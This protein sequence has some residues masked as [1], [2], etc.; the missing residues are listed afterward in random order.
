LYSR[1]GL[2]AW[3]GVGC[4]TLGSAVGFYAAGV[5]WALALF[6]GLCVALGL[7]FA[8]L[9]AWMQAPKFNWRFGGFLVG[10]ALSGAVLGMGAG[11]IVAVVTHH[12]NLSSGE[13]WFKVA[14]AVVSGFPISS[15]VVL[16]LVAVMYATAA[17]RRSLMQKALDD[18][19]LTQ[20]RDAAARQAAEAQL[21]LLRA[22]IQ[23][24]F[25]FNTLSALQHWVDTAGARSP[26]SC[27]APPSCWAV[28]R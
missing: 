10:L 20:E 23:P 16:A 11:A 24:H 25:I 26:V 3:I 12:Q 2:P 15:A 22:Q 1:R 9:N 6:G 14:K 17:A 21:K 5:H 27:A 7:F 8:M 13:A 28:T 18:A 4:S 19:R